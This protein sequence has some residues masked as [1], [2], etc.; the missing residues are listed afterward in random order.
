MKLE[1][2]LLLDAC[3]DDAFDDGI[4]IDSELEPLS[5]AGGPVKPAVYPGGSYQQDRR[6]A[7]PGDDAP[8]PVIVIDNVPSQA[9]RLEHALWRDREAS[10]I[11]EVVLDLSGLGALPAHL[12]RSLSA[13]VCAGPSSSAR[14]PFPVTPRFL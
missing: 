1:L 13:A 10:G 6:W 14:S 9:N 4:R 8:T 3:A 11:P 7:T 12:P 5:G 2:P